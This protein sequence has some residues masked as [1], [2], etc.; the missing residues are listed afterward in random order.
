MY[1]RFGCLIFVCFG[2]V[3]VCRDVFFFSSRR[4]HTRCALVTGV[5]TCALPISFVFFL[6]DR[7]FGVLSAHVAGPDAAAYAFTS[8]L[9]TQLLQSLAAQLQPILERVP[10]PPAAEPPPVA[11]PPVAETVDGPVQIGR[12]H[13]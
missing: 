4:R 12:A 8:A 10:Q 13:V 11:E 9:P 3:I 6:G 1:S 7:F 2:S 5:Q